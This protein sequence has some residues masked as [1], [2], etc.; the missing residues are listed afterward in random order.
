MISP[1]VTIITASHSLD[2][3]E[4]LKHAQFNKPVTIGKNVWI[5]ANVTIF[6]GVTIGDNSVIGAGS[7]VSK[8]VP[9]DVLA[10][11]APCRVVRKSR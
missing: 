2:P 1:N 6:P 11:G 7:I 9:S 3:E 4:R 5:G 10:Y 8:D